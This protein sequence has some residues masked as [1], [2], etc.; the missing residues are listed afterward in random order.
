MIFLNRNQ[1][2]SSATSDHVT[3]PYGCC[4]VDG[5]FHSDE[6]TDSNSTAAEPHTYDATCVHEMRALTY[7][8]S[9]CRAFLGIKHGVGEDLSFK[10]GKC[11]VTFNFS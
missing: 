9:S 10:Q 8:E 2:P 7:A 1:N 6:T 3:L 4:P 11:S 5:R